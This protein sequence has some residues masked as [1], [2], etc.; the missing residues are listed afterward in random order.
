MS[1]P[2]NNSVL[3]LGYRLRYGGS[4]P[5][6]S[7]GC[8]PSAKHPD[9]LCGPPSPLSVAYQGMKVT[10]HVYLAPKIRIRGAIP[11]F[12]A[13]DFMPWTGTTSAIDSAAT[14]FLLH[15]FQSLLQADC[16]SGYYVLLTRPL[17][18]NTNV[19]SHADYTYTVSWLS[20]SVPKLDT[21]WLYVMLARVA[22]YWS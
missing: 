1:P 11:P 20:E 16:I 12:Q 5:Y 22:K 13:Q 7:Q 8:F 4:N 14:H 21:T 17:H 9:R 3:W 6:R 18:R 2:F 19:T 10:S 15:V